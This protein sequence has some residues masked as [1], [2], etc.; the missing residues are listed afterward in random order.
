MNILRNGV[1]RIGYELRS[2]F[3][4]PD[5][6][7]FTFLFPILMFGLFASI[8]AGDELGPGPDGTTVS[9]SRYYLTGMLAMAILLTGT[10]NLAIDIAIE[11][12]EGGL[13]R[14]GATPLS[15]VSFFIGKFGVTVITCAVQMVLLI[16]FARL[17]FDVELP[18]DPERWLTFAWV[19]LLG[20]ACFSAL[21]TALS[22]VPRSGR[23]ATAIVIPVVLLPQFFSGIFISFSMLPEWL[24]NVSSAL[25][26]AWLARGM[27]SVFMPEWFEAS[28]PGGEWRLPVAALVI[29]IWF[30]AGLLVS[31][32]TFRWTRGRS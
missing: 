9:M 29:G 17:A 10:Q 27:R 8:F 1:S 15:P 24:Q 7:F 4:A 30:V 20:L 16:V 32:F 5:Q 23:S 31:W 18:S 2:Y 25:P 19:S 3:R 6:V 26:L 21:G 22:A 13:K 28:E 12:H 14:L 11:K